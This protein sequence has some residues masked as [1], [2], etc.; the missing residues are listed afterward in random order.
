MLGPSP[1]FQNMRII[2]ATATKDTQDSKLG[3]AFTRGGPESPLTIKSI[4]SDSVFAGSDLKPGMIVHT[5]MGDVMTWVTPKDAADTLR[6]ADAGEVT[7]DALAFV[8]EIIKEEKS[9][10][11]GIALK[12]S[13]IKPGIYIS[14]ISDTG[15]F[16]GCDLVPGQKVLYIND[17]PCPST[18]K[19]AISLVKEAEG[20]LK[21][22]TI[23][24]DMV[25]PSPSQNET[26]EVTEEEKKEVTSTNENE[27]VGEK[28][29]QE[30]DEVAEEDKGILD[31]IFSTC[32]C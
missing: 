10:K 32:M 23:P 9:A 31:K 7:L 19:E 15:A 8:A 20:K 17:T 4:N 29:I 11:L 24:T 5:V 25:G 6:L 27:S 1:P 28:D 21:I 16:A 22:I 18:V 13:T 26:S 14:S 30:E 2:K 12:N 3:I